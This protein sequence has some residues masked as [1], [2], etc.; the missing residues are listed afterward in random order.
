MEPVISVRVN[1]V[2]IVRA[3]MADAAWKIDMDCR[4]WKIIDDNDM[5]TM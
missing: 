3:T 4:E 1:R 5:M 2:G